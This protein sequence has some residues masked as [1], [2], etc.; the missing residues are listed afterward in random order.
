MEYDPTATGH[1]VQ[2]WAYDGANN[3]LPKP[4]LD[5]QGAKPMPE[6][7]LACHGGRFDGTTK[8]VSKAAFL[9]FD[10]D[11]FLYDS[12]GDPHLSAVVQEQFRQLNNIV[13]N[14][15]P[16]SLTGN[17][18]N[19]ITQL[20][21]LWYPAGVGTTNAPYSFG[22]AVAANQGGFPGHGPLYDNVVKPLCRT[23]HVTRSS[24]DDWTL[25]TQMNPP[26]I[27][28]YACGAGNPHTLHF[29]NY[30]AMPHA[31]VPFKNFWL[32][33]LSSTLDS[34]LGLNGCPNN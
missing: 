30:F 2:F 29:P 25:F 9:P 23:C 24:G 28:L 33:S 32:N 27:K 20:M 4:T 15:H 10:L 16:D 19:P 1:E 6:M 18:N 17:S 31:E 34:E 5:G 13:L 7:C 12:A 11:S 14:T 3:Y 26:T 21:N 8:T 22:R